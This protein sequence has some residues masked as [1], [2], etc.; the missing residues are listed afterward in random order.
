MQNCQIII[1]REDHHTVSFSFDDFRIAQAI[2]NILDNVAE[3]QRINIE[4]KVD[5]Y[6]LK[7][8]HK[9]IHEE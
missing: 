1:K 3:P 7:H 6:N 8:I 2:I 4:N 9:E 5:F